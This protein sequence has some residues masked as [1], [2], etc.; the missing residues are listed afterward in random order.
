MKNVNYGDYF[1]QRGNSQ[2]Q[3][4]QLEGILANA[5]CSCSATLNDLDLPSKLSAVYVGF[6]E[7]K[8]YYFAG[9]DSVCYYCGSE[10]IYI[11]NT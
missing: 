4:T 6:H 7:K 3:Q 11:F 9:Y 1:S 2:L 5:T 8:L 10:Y